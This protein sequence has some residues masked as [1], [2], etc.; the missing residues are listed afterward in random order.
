MIK[1]KEHKA[2]EIKSQLE[3]RQTLRKGPRQEKR[4]KGR[5]RKKVLKTACW[6][7]KKGLHKEK[8]GI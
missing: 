3:R 5:C 2:N 1:K 7:K 6:S 4:P 8:I